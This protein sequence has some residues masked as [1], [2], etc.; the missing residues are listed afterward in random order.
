[1]SLPATGGKTAIPS[2][3][4]RFVR[5][6]IPVI[7]LFPRSKRPTVRWERYQTSLPSHGQTQLWFGGN[8]GYNAAVVCGWHG[9]TVLD[10]DNNGKYLTWLTWA[11]GEDEETR[12]LALSTYQVKTARGVH[13][14]YF[15][16]DTPECHKMGRG[17]RT[18][19]R[20]FAEHWGEIK[21][22][23][24]YVVIPPSIHPSG[25]PYRAMDA[26][27]EI[28]TIDTLA[29]VLPE[30]PVDE[31]LWLRDAPEWE[32]D[33]DFWPVRGSDCFPGSPVEEIKKHLSVLTLL[34][35]ARSSGGARWYMANCPL[36][37]DQHES[38]WVDADR[39]LCGCYAGCT[40][41]G[42]PL[43]V[44]GLYARINNLSNKEAIRELARK[45]GA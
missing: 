29:D 1:M 9:L 28:L 36:H 12:H 33:P 34:P 31:P 10:F 20:E 18:R 13:V 25:A 21:G 3:I 22:R 35:N 38:M 14:Y 37:D 4:E 43:D 40:P 6:C 8:A 32:P 17:Y 24:G 42:R 23:R 5:A 27:A 39:G 45:V 26:T 19:K 11:M 7:P 30:P 2:E 15:V 16:A 44:I 41:E